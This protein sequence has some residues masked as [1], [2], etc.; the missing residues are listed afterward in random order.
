[1]GSV[2]TQI[3]K[4]ENLEVVAS[5]STD[6]IALVKK[7]GADHV[8]DYTAK[9]AITQFSDYGPYDIILDCAGKGL[10]YATQ[11]PWK[12]DQY[13]T[14]TSPLLKNIDT[15]GLGIGFFKNIV[16]ILDSNIQ[17]ISKYRAL[18]KWAYF[19]PAPQG[20]EYLK[21]QVERN[22]IVPCVDSVFDFDA[23]TDAYMKIANGHLRGKVILKIK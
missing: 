10:D 1:M 6:A 9:D 5:C 20:I 17:T 2:A 11:I 19:V 16:N 23:T 22:K 3:G 21:K 8:I 14:F 4:A 15:N 12:F 13:I 7:L 18:S